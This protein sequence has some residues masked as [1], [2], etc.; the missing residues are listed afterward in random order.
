MTLTPTLR[1]LVRTAHV[2]FTVGWLGAVAGF[3]A[4]AVTGLNSQD[5]Q[6]VRSAYLAMDLITRFVIVPLSI[7]PLLVT[8][9]LLSL[10]TP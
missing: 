9:P 1:K 7:A 8:G 6:I 5:T 2:T 3:L 10:A 4:L